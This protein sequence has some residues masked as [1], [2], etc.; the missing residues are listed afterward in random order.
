MSKSLDKWNP[1]FL[2]QNTLLFMPLQAE[3]YKSLYYLQWKVRTRERK[4]N[5]MVGLEKDSLGFP[6]HIVSPLLSS[7]LYFV[8]VHLLWPHGVFSQFTGIYSESPDIACSWL[9]CQILLAGDLEQWNRTEE[10]LA[11]KDTSYLLSWE[12][13]WQGT[14]RFA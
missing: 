1:L 9:G 13:K 8:P 4:S 10:Q 12:G 6:Y 7:L 5:S 11:K 2:P 3:E 14:T